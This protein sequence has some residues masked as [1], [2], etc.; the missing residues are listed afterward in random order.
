[1]RRLFPAVVALALAPAP[2]QAVV[3]GTTAAAG[4]YPYTANIDISNSAGCTG[5]LVA[6]TWVITAGH[7]TAITG[8]FGAPLAVTLPPSAYTVTLGTINADGSGGEAHSVKSVHVDPDY[9][10]TN[11][12]GS[13]VSLLELSTPSS[14]EP[15]QI[16]AP[17][18]QAIWAPGAL[19]TIAGFGTTSE[20]D[21]T[22]PAKLQVA[23]VP[24]VADREC[25][26]EYSDTTPV[27]GNAF[28]PQTALC[29]G[30]PKGGKDTCEG[31]SGGPL[32]APLGTGFRLVGATSYGEG[33]ARAGKAGIY[34]RL[35]EGPV[36][37][38]LAQYVPGAFATVAATCAGTKGLTVHLRHRRRVKVYVA[39]RLV[40]RVRTARVNLAPLLPRAGRVR[41]RIVAGRRV[42]RRTYTDCARA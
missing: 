3:G 12:T 33:C 6:P 8:A 1:M 29:A 5:S 37:A 13:D 17:G 42:V 19:L 2:A 14:V 16:A 24:R 39:G 7:C 40:L 30:Y 22:L 20:S 21:S 31:D 28:D 18:E 9:A 26:N 38:F 34:A 36:K 27:V 10:V 4:A 11:G 35:A 15:I 32:L 25:A 23:Q 41:V